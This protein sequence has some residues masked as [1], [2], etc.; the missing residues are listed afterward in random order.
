MKNKTSSS[1]TNIPKSTEEKYWFIG[2]FSEVVLLYIWWCIFTDHIPTVWFGPMSILRATDYGEEFYYLAAYFSPFFL[3][4]SF[5]RNSVFRYTSVLF[6]LSLIGVPSLM[7]WTLRDRTLLVCFGTLIGIPAYF[8][9]FWIERRRKRAVWAHLLALLALVSSRF[10]FSTLYPIWINEQTTWITLGV[11]VLSVLVLSFDNVKEPNIDVQKDRSFSFFVDLKLGVGFGALLFLTH[12]L[13]TSH[14]VIPR[15]ID[16][17]PF[18]YGIGYLVAFVVGIFLNSYPSF[19]RGWTW[20]LV[21]SISGPLLLSP[22]F[23]NSQAIFFGY[24]VVAYLASV[25][26]SIAHDLGSQTKLS[27]ALS[28]ASLVYLIGNFAVIWSVA[29][30][31]VPKGTGGPFMR[32]RAGQ[33]FVVALYLVS[34]GYSSSQPKEVKKLKDDDDKKK[35]STTTKNT[36]STPKS[37]EPALHSTVLVVLILI[38]LAVTAPAIYHRS[39]SYKNYD[40]YEGVPKDHVRGMAWAIRFGYDNFG[41]AN[42]YDVEAKIKE[43]RANTIALVETDITRPFNGNRDI[44]EY[45]TQ[46]LHMYSDYGPATMNET[47][48]C[49]LFS[50]FPI[51]RADHETLPSPEGENACLI[52]ATLDVN[53]EKVDIIA[54]HVGNT[55]HVLD[56]ELQAADMAQR[57]RQKVA[58][59]RKVIWLGYLTDKP[60]GNNYQKLIN[61]GLVDVAP[62]EYNRYC[63]YLFHHGMDVKNFQRIDVGDITDTEI[64]IAD[65]Y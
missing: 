21:A 49:A 30:C 18:V 17:D 3:Y 32:E 15:W 63:I 6:F 36:S 28:I 25:W 46:H 26:Q 12:W 47:W 41:W 60:R 61:A 50:I 4:L 35:S 65:F 10:A 40:G 45:L 2:F 24:V 11:G 33:I 16:L 34:L 38:L 64:Q 31:F 7:M 42:F 14:S 62:N 59:K 13:L 29:Y 52:D 39:L 37:S 54:V 55:E 51:V 23:N 48:G 44:V 19:V 9:Q 53:G 1:T 27:R 43:V 20:W 22:V 5:F 8:A 56:R 58:D 57:V